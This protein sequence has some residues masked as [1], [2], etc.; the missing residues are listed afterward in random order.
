PRLPERS[1]K[2]DRLAAPR[3]SYTPD[4]DLTVMNRMSFPRSTPESQ[5]IQSRAILDF[6]EAADH[7]IRYLH[8]LMLVRRGVVVAEGYWA[9]YQATD[10][11]ILFSLSKSFTST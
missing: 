10:P 6:V 1:P 5:G 8:S 9:P 7:D 3:V 2:R 11:H 4:E